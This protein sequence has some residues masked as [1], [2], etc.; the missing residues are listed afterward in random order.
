MA[1]VRQ[2]IAMI[3]QWN[4]HLPPQPPT[5]PAAIAAWNGTAPQG[6]WVNGSSVAYAVAFANASGPSQPGPWSTFAPSTVNAFPTLANLPVD[7]LKMATNRWIYRQFLKADGTK[8]PI[9]IVGIT[10]ATSTTY[11][12]TQP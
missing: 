12:D 10:D 2:W 3:Q 5:T 11:Q 4:E 7:P 8:S 1:T 6:D 9:R